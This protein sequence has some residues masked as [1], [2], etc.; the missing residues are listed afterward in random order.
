MVLGEYC[1]IMPEAAMRWAGSSSPHNFNAGHI[2]TTQSGH[3]WGLSRSP[4]GAVVKA[5]PPPE[6]PAIPLEIY[7]EPTLSA[8][9]TRI[10][11]RHGRGEHVGD[12]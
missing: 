12:E 5:L 6:R 9:P 8:S 10:P 4:A 11:A 2:F 1:I 7:T 3:I